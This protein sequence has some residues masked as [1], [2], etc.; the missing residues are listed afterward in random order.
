MP[1]TT[2]KKSTAPFRNPKAWTPNWIAGLII[3]AVYSSA[4][5]LAPLYS[6]AAVLSFYFLTFQRALLFSL[7]FIISV[8]LPPIHAPKLLASLSPIATGYFQYEEALEQSY[9]EFEEGLESGTQRKLLICMQPHGVVSFTSFCMN[10]MCPPYHRR[11]KTAVAT[12]ILWVP[13]LKHL[14]GINGLV[15]ASKA[16][17][18]KHFSKPGV[19][20]CAILYVGGIAELFKCNRQEERLFLSKRKGFIKLALRENVDIVPVYLFG[21][22]SILSEW[23]SNFLCEVSRKTGVVLTYF[24]GKWGLPIPRDEQILVARGKPMGLPHIVNPTQADI[25]HWHA[26]YCQEVMRLFDTYKE[27]LPN[28]KNKKLYID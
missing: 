28:Y 9:E 4:F 11:V 10:I 25:D 12:S 2:A 17:L 19:D 27:K 24:W 7:P 8:I 6:I 15:S 26:K 21:N 20:G 18:K 23:H 22:T 1:T 13:I 3:A 5:I 16:N 14:L